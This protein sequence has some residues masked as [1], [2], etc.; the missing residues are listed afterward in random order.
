MPRA[1]RVAAAAATTGTSPVRSVATPPLPSPDRVASETMTLTSDDSP[2]GKGKDRYVV[3]TL[4][5]YKIEG[6]SVGGQETCIILPQLKI[7]FDSG[8]CP[9]R[10]VYAD[11]LCLSHTHL[12]HVGGAG[13]YIATRSLLSLPPPTVLLP[14]QRADAFEAYV[15]SLR[16]LDGSELPHVAV[17]IE[18][19]ETH[20]LSKLH[21][22]RPFPTTHPV[23]S[24]GYV[25]YGTKR[26]LRE[27]YAGLSG[28]EIKA[29]RDA[30]TV[31]TDSIEVPEVAFTGDASGE[32]TRS[33]HPVARDA[34]RA[35]LLICECT[36]VDD[37]VDVEGAREYGHTHID[38]LAAAADAFDNERILLIHF[39]A[40]YK[41]GEVTEAIEK[42]LP[43]G[44]RER[45][46]PML[47]GFN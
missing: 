6:I 45:C 18:P 35:K 16:A 14:A 28:Q 10:C 24:Q 20:V 12:D 47:V 17:P 31:V 11:T 42:R 25:V 2:V 19:G 9:Q 43:A 33:D 22:V 3:H 7:A 26:K 37:A 21:C 29:L 23:A 15:A 13:H 4:A 38:E 36:F 27:E 44:L 46:V 32:W 30:G 5:G 39:S 40:R 8:R 41:A 34:L 1:L